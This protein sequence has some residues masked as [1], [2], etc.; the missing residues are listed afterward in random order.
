MMVRTCS[1]KTQTARDRLSRRLPSSLIL[2]VEEG[3]CFTELFFLV[4]II[5]FDRVCAGK[6]DVA[7]RL[8]TGPG[9]QETT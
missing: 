8:R 9:L 6:K 3:F 2:T 5:I 7:A 1:D 4:P